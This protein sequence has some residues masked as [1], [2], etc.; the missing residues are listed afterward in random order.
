MQDLRTDLFQDGGY[1]A[2]P[3]LTLETKIKR[4][5]C[6]T[7]DKEYIRRLGLIVLVWASK[8]TFGP[9]FKI[10]KDHSRDFGAS[11]LQNLYL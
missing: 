8:Q 2:I 9:K 3:P 10:L 11:R 1:D 5:L 6:Y 7:F 4:S